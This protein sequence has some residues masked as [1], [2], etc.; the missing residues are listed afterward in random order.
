MTSVSG[1]GQAVRLI[2]LRCPCDVATAEAMVSRTL[3]GP[4]RADHRTLFGGDRC[5]ESSIWNKGL[6]SP[7][8]GVL[9]L[10]L[11]CV[12]GSTPDA[13]ELSYLQPPRVRRG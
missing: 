2:M 6:L 9:R 7:E 5:G 11:A 10:C 13:S 8:P 12:A 1:R 3:S 4:Y